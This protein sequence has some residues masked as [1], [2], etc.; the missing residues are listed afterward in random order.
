MY[1][2]QKKLKKYLEIESFILL[3]KFFDDK[4]I[5]NQSYMLKN[6]GEIIINFPEPK[7]LKSCQRK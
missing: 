6:Q 1:S 7:N 3:K 2:Y 4:L 5:L